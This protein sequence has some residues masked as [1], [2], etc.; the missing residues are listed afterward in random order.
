M[1]WHLHDRRKPFLVFERQANNRVKQPAQP[2]TP[3]AL[4]VGGPGT[5]PEKARA[6]PGHA[7]AYP[8]RYTHSLRS[9]TVTY[10]VVTMYACPS[11]GLRGTTTRLIRTSGS[12]VSHSKKRRPCSPTNTP[13]CLTTRN[14]PR[15]NIASFSLDLVLALEPWSYVTATGKPVMSF[16]SSQLGRHPEQS[17]IDT[18]E[19]GANEKGIRFFKGPT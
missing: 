14:I 3:L 19:G 15:P 11:C 9:L 4:D 18:I 10:D 6:A 12:T 17:G 2:V 1:T 16:A 13:C 5:G 7:A 8:G